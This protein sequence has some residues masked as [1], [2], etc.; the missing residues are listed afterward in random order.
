MEREDEFERRE[1]QEAAEEAAKIGGKP[2]V[3]SS[4]DDDPDRPGDHGDPAMEPVY[5]GGGGEAEGFEL[6]EAELID[7]AENPRG[8][9]PMADQE[10]VSEDV[11]AE[12]V[13]GEADEEHTSE[14]DPGESER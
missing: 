13:Y 4:F 9:S 2:G 10:R 5:E 8:P 6:A 12:Q 1:E 11:R 3:D 7:R 14:D